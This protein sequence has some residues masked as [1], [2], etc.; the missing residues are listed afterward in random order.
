MPSRIVRNRKFT[1]ITGRAFGSW[2]VIARVIN[3]KGHTRWLC[4][5]SCGTERVQLYGTLN[6]RVTESCGCQKSRKSTEAGA[7]GKEYVTEKACPTCGVVK[8]VAGFTYRAK[9]DKDSPRRCIECYEQYVRKERMQDPEFAAK[10]RERMR[11]YFTKPNVKLRM[12][13]LKMLRKFGLTLDQYR[14]M[15]DSQGGA[16]AICGTAPPGEYDLRVDHCH[17]TGK[18]RGLL[19]ATCNLALGNLG[20]TAAGVHRAVEYLCRAEGVPP[21][22]WDTGG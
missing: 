15:R 3:E 5:C 11:V 9:L 12:R 4:R 7:R 6:C 1:D 21:P 13:E 16:C 8:P 20:D 10:H 14:A 18:I 2:T 19:C 22:V 17:A